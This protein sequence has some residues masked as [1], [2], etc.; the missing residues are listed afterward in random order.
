MSPGFYTVLLGKVTVVWK[1]GGKNSA[2]AQ[3]LRFNP[4][5]ESSQPPAH[6][7]ILRACRTGF[8]LEIRRSDGQRVTVTGSVRQL[9]HTRESGAV[10]KRLRDDCIKNTS[11]R[12]C[13][14]AAALEA[15]FTDSSE[16]S[17]LLSKV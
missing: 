6:I 14:I 13:P 11:E 10:C 5:W 4:C 7:P 17:N 12:T 1:G 3:T 8:Q 9:A 2:K 16:F 15:T